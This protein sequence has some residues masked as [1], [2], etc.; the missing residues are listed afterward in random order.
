MARKRHEADP[1][2][3]TAVTAPV[4][5]PE[6]VR[7]DAALRPVRFEEY[8][9]QEDLKRPLYTMVA[10]AR[11]RREAIDH[12]LFY[13]P[14]G[15]GKTTL[16]HII[17]HEMGV[18]LHQTSGP[19]VEHKGVLAGLLTN[20]A[21]RDVLFIDEIHRLPP[22]V[23]EALYPAME[24][25]T[26]DVLIGDGP[27]AKAITMPLP[28]FTLVGATTRTGMLTSPLRDRF[29]FSWRLTYYT[30]AELTEIIRRSA[31]RL[32][33]PVTEDGAAELGRRARGTP[34]VANRWLRRA[35]DY[36]E[37]EG[38]GRI[39]HAVADRAL[40]DLQVDAAGLNPMDRLYLDRLIHRFHGGPVG[41]EAIAAAL[42]EDRQTLE[43]T[44]EPF[45][46]QQGFVDRT[47]RGRVATELAI[48]HLGLAR[49]VKPDKPQQDLF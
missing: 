32:G 18:T 36:A 46:L 8:I 38:D 45:L 15:L 27:H 21:E 48:T 3:T 1:P 4:S 6:D 7:A 19:A 2:E 31:R 14:P 44:V 23:E 13:G 34:R 40:G 16:A 49:L 28:R 17:A 12:L 11:A 37:V 5:T 39:D 30:E 29:G 47:S 42:S 22:P 9:G 43:D 20:L 10:A 25:F 41:I 33:V 26:L 35:R 24:D